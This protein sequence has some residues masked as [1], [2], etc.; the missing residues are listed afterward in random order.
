MG[1]GVVSYGVFLWHGPIVLAFRD[2]GL[3]FP[4]R[5]GFLANLAII[6]SVTVL[7]S[8]ATYRLV[9]EPS[10]RR[11]ARSRPV[12]RDPEPLVSA[13]EQAAAS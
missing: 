7:L 2:W 9:E 5:A 12:A 10:L 4:G 11:R 3:T 6:G 13:A 1:I 8:I